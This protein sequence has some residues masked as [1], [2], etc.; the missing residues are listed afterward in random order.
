MLAPV[1]LPDTTFAD[2]DGAL[3]KLSD[4]RGRVTM[5]VFTNIVC[6]EDTAC[7]QPLPVYQQV[8]RELGARANDVAFVF[9]GVDPKKDTAEA[10]NAHVRAADA[11][12]LG[13]TGPTS[14]LRPL[15]LRFGIHMNVS[16]D[17]LLAHAPFIYLLDKQTRLR[18]YLPKRLPVSAIVPEIEWLLGE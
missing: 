16:D 4:L 6:V 8:K 15:T 7:V 17:T 14:T 2:Q 13:W 11:A 12:F 5:I 1:E 10:L 3:A 9:V 18:V